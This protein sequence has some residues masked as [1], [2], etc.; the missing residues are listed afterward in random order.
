MKI[1]GS[2]TAGSITF[3][4]TKANKRGRNLVGT[5]VTFAIPAPSKIKAKACSTAGGP[6]TLRNLHVTAPR[7]QTLTRA[8]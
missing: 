4:V 1:K 2:A 5:S 6:L 3:T 7:A 8:R